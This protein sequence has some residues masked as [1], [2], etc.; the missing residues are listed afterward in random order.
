MFTYLLTQVFYFL[1]S[2]PR[3]RRIVPGERQLSLTSVHPDNVP[4]EDNVLIAS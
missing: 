1:V 4:V 3:I 2:Q